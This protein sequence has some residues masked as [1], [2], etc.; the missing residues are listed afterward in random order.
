MLPDFA[1]CQ[2]EIVTA[3]VQH[4]KLL[5]DV[6]DAQ[7]SGNDLCN[8]GRP[9]CARN[10]H[11]KYN[12]EHQVKHHVYDAGQNQEQQ[13]RPAVAQCAQ[14][15]RQDIKQHSCKHA[16]ID[17]N[18]I[19][20]GIV[21]NGRRGL[22]GNQNRTRQRYRNCGQDNGHDCANHDIGREAAPHTL[23]IIRTKMPCGLDG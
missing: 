16:C 17:N 11:L 3:H 14:D 13:R 15:V 5:A 23:Q 8:H 4:G 18:N 20:I 2:T 12:D 9:R 7:Q 21:Q 22:H 6:H 19:G 10:A 1:P